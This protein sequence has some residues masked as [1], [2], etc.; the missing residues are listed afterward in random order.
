MARLVVNPGSPV[1]WEIQL[2]PGANLIGRGFAN[3]FKIA[4]PSVS[5]SHCQIDVSAQGAVIKDLGSTNGTFINRAPVKESAL[6]PGQTV[7]LGGVE[8]L[9]QGDGPPAAP[10]VR[11]APVGVA[12]GTAQMAAG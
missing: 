9:F 1:A 8:L 2:K 11:A 5:S 7:H 4:D 6:Q 12:I 10:V 3:D